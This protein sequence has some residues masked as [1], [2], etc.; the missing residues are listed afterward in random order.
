MRT[1]V[2]L[3][4]RLVMLGIAAGALFFV[5]DRVRPAHAVDPPVGEDA[6]PEPPAADLPAPPPPTAPSVS[7]PPTVPLPAVPAPF[8]PTPPALP[9]VPAVPAVPDGLVPGI[10]APA[11]AVPDGLVPAA[12]APAPP[13]TPE[14]PAIDV[15][16]VTRALGP[17]PSVPSVPSVSAPEAELPQLPALSDE[18]PPVRALLDLVAVTPSTPAPVIALGRLTTVAVPEPAR[19][20]VGLFDTGW[21]IPVLDLAHAPA[22]APPPPPQSPIHSCP[23]G[24]TSHTSRTEW[25][26]SLPSGADDAS[27]RAALL[28]DARSYASTLLLDPVLRPD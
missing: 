14:I 28:A 11:P 10:T 9:A 25:A 4:P 23:G 20:G 1:I 6:I 21:T 19:S 13:P 26:G 7:A 3:L 16:K 8:L 27:R 18:L 12:P 17:V 2:R 24:G 15:E 22:R 5:L